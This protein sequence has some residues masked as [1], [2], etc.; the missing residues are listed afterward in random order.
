MKKISTLL[1][2]SAA[3]AFSASAVEPV[4]ITL[5]N[6]SFEEADASIIACDRL[7]GWTVIGSDAL[8][9]DGTS[10][11][12]YASQSRPKSWSDGSLGLR[13]GAA[14]D[15]TG[16]NYLTQTLYTQKAGVYVL[17]FDGRTARTNWKNDLNSYKYDDEGNVVETLYKFWDMAFIND[18]YGMN[19]T[20]FVPG[21]PSEEEGT[22][23][24]W[25]NGHSEPNG[26]FNN[27]WPR[28]YLIHKTSPDTF[29]EGTTDITFGFG[30]PASNNTDADGNPVNLTKAQIA[31]DNFILRFFDTED[32]QVAKDW[33]NAEIAKIE[34]GDYS[35]PALPSAPQDP[36]NA[37]GAVKQPMHVANGT[38]FNIPIGTFVTNSGWEP[39][40]GINDIVAPAVKN[41]KYYNLQGIEIA[42]PTQAGIYIHN[43][44]KYIVR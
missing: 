10:S 39:S 9:E 19:V 6:P 5:A 37:E 43:G 8:K 20:D 3:L 35:M 24:L 13:S 41:D 12:L 30:F 14:V 36:S 11:F 42:K 31:C 25:S 28:Y 44:K 15:L 18:D 2:A 4:E 26:W 32:I 23:I 27:N 40:T 16:A 38:A 1:M 22:T 34:A 29:D 33:V 7:V 17:Q 21:E